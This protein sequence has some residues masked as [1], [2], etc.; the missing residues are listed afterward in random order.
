MSLALKITRHL[1]RRLTSDTYPKNRVFHPSIVGRPRLLIVGVYIANAPNYVTHLVDEFK[2]ATLVDVEQRWACMKGAPPNHSVSAVTAVSLND[3]V[4]KWKLVNDLIAPKD[5]EQ[6]DYFAIC[7][8]DIRVGRGFIDCFVAEQQALDFAL[9][10]PARTWRSFTDHGIVR[11]RLFTRARQTSFVEGGP[12]VFFRNDFFRINYPFSLESPMGWGYD[13]TWPII[14]RERGFMI[15]IIDSVPLDHS[16]R[17]RGA[18]YNDRTEID[19]MARYLATRPHVRAS[20][21]SRALRVY[22]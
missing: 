9:A 22:R 7:D 3:F 2:T 5:L 14:A 12:L 1:A 17:V 11:R 10:Q 21:V 4:P 13:L 15:G 19:I 8:D 18:L 20:E 16:L 6:F